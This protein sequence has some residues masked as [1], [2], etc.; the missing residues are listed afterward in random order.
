M[1]LSGRWVWRLMSCVIWD[2]AD[3]YLVTKVPEAT[4]TYIFSIMPP[5]SSE[6]L[7]PIYQTAGRHIAKVVVFFSGIP[8]CLSDFFLSFSQTSCWTCWMQNQ[9]SALWCISLVRSQLSL[10]LALSVFS[11]TVYKCL[12]SWFRVLAWTVRPDRVGSSP[13]CLSIRTCVSPWQ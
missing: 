5:T 12:V 2:R 10:Y 1:W 3:W 9:Q 7:L 13:T 6:T 8:I 4:V 11:I